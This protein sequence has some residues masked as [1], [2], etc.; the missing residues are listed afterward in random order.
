MKLDWIKK[1]NLVT[2]AEIDSTNSEALRIAS[3]NLRGDFV[4]LA[5]TQTGGR[6]TKGR[7]WSSFKGNLHMSILL[8]TDFALE[9]NL[10]LPFL[11]A[12]AVFEAISY[13]AKQEN[14]AVNM[15]LKWPNDILIDNEKVAG[16]LLEQINLNRKNYVVIGIGL[17]IDKFPEI[18]Q[19]ATCLRDH[20]IHCKDPETFLHVLMAK[21][22]KLHTKWKTTDSF[23][24]I[25]KDWMKRAYNL[26]KIIVINDGVRR[27]SGIFKDIDS[28]GAMRLELANGDYC[29]IIA[30]DISFPC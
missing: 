23:V 10:Q 3:K 8:Q 1:Y 7:S 4:I 18:E 13:F 20:N 16:I 17:N 2:F 12:N 28:N 22:D 9:R 21:F 29:S 11:T 26:N 14:V 6:G 19:N 5:K 25:R 30:G 24:E 15:K 27:I